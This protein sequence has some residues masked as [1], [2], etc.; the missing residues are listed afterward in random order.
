MKVLRRIRDIEKDDKLAFLN[1]PYNEFTV[2]GYE[3]KPFEVTVYLTGKLD[4]SIYATEFK[5]IFKS[6]DSVLVRVSPVK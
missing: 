3:F 2:T 1:D 4:D 6:D 5:T